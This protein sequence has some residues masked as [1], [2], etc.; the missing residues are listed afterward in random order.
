MN[1]F[2][3]EFMLGEKRFE[4]KKE[5][6]LAVKKATSAAMKEA[7]KITNQKTPADSRKNRPNK[8]QDSKWLGGKSK[9]AAVQGA[10]ILGSGIAALG[11][12]FK[13]G[14][15]DM[16]KAMALAASGGSVSSTTPEISLQHAVINSG[17]DTLGSFLD[18]EYRIKKMAMEELEK[19]EYDNWTND[20][21]KCDIIIKAFQDIDKATNFIIFPAKFR[22]K[23]LDQFCRSLNHDVVNA[24]LSLGKET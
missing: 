21:A 6:L 23:I 3:Y 20:P 12:H 8:D 10:T 16:A 1:K 11:G 22:G 7:K 14:F 17:G 2:W 19:P 24:M 15:Q 18:K 9:A 4:M 5:K 13:E